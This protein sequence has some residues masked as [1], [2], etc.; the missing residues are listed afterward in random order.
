MDSPLGLAIF[1]TDLAHLLGGAVLVASFGLLYQR[2]LSAL[3]TLYALQAW[4]VAAAA[5]W[6]SWAQGSPELLATGLIAGAAKGVAIPWAL[7]TIVRRLRVER[8]V[9]SALGVFPSMIAGVA[10]VLLAVLAVQPATLAAQALARENLALALSVVL[11]GLLMMTTR[12][13]ALT[14]VVGFLSLENGLALAAVGGRGLPLVA[15]LSVGVLVLA[16]VAVFGVFFFR[17]RDRFDTLDLSRLRR[18][19]R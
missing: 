8:S 17:I 4:A 7:R 19:V 3:I 10:L 16:G 12:R 11:L 6:Q 2:R 9:E 18:R 15:E 1:G 14:Q 5:L 13:T